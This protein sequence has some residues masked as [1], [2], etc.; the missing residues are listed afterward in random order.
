MF[1]Y[2]LFFLYFVSNYIVKLQCQRWINRTIHIFNT[3]LYIYKCIS[4]HYQSTLTVPDNSL[5]L[6]SYSGLSNSWCM[7]IDTILIYRWWLKYS[8]RKTIYSYMVLKSRD[9]VIVL[10]CDF[11]LIMEF[12]FFCIFFPLRIVTL[13]QSELIFFRFRFF[14]KKPKLMSSVRYSYKK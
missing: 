12:F 11:V 1:H 9:L 13:Y 14:S 4:L 2:V 10:L 8:K 6:C 7:W 3:N 5:T